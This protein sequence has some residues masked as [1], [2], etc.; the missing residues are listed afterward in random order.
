MDNMVCVYCGKKILE[1]VSCCPFCGG[2]VPVIQNNDAALNKI[3]AEKEI[4]LLSESKPV[5]TIKDILL[6]TRLEME[7]AEKAIKSL[8][9]K[10]I[11]SEKQNN[12]GQSTYSVLGESLEKIKT[13][14]KG[15]S[16]GTIFLRTHNIF[17]VKRKLS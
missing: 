12:S 16:T 11:V 17:C 15:L 10:G 9:S 13:K 8:I 3:S 1:N 2:T 5:F 7:E 14:T 4:L 6:N